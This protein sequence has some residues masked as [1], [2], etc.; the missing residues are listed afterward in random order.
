MI[1]QLGILGRLLRQPVQTQFTRVRRDKLGSC[2]R[3]RR[4]CGD[5]RGNSRRGLL[6]DGVC[7]PDPAQA[8]VIGDY[9]AHRQA[10]LGRDDRFP[11]AEQT[12]F[13]LWRLIRHGH[14]GQQKR[15]PG[16]EAVGV[17]DGKLE[18]DLVRFA[19]GYPLGGSLLLAPRSLLRR[20]SRERFE[21]DM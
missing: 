2:G 4:I 9:A 17:A 1:R 14:Q 21:C 18:P 5:F 11:R 10:S 12:D 20:G 8:V 16:L 13:D 15:I 6:L 3:L 19:A 7:P